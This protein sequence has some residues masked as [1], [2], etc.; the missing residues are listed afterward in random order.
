MDITRIVGAAALSVSIPVLAM[1]QP[2]NLTFAKG[3]QVISETETRAPL[4]HAAEPR[5]NILQAD[6]KTAPAAAA[7]T[8]AMTRLSDEA[9]GVD[10]LWAAYKTQCSPKATA[11]VPF[12]REWFA[13]LGE[14]SPSSATSDC[15]DL[16]TL[17]KQTGQGIR[18]DLQK[19]MISARRSN[20]DPGTEVGLLRWNSLELPQAQMS[21]ARR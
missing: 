1:V 21:M 8:S 6:V 16:L 19:A 15:D 9:D 18:Q 7:F 4:Q 13:V 17:V 5:E 14:K 20:L 10:R 12:G 3:T 11:E 2:G